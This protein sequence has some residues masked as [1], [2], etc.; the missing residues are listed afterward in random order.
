[1]D[2]AP[3][4]PQVLLKLETWLDRHN[5]RHGD[6]LSCDAIWVTDGVGFSSYLLTAIPDPI[7]SSLG[8]YGVFT[9]SAMC[10]VTDLTLVSHLG[11]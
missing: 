7:F 5:L 10:R 8:T 6:E 3:T 9:Y 11:R 4:F 1:M 2:A